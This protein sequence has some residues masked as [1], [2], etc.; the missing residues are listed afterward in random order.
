MSTELITYCFPHFKLTP[1]RKAILDAYL[2]EKYPVNPPV[3]QALL[4]A[5]IRRTA[6]VREH[7]RCKEITNAAA[8]KAAIAELP[9]IPPPIE[10][11]GDVDEDESFENKLVRDYVEVCS[12]P[13]SK[14]LESKSKDSQVWVFRGRVFYAGLCDSSC[15]NHSN[16]IEEMMNYG[17]VTDVE[18]NAMLKR[19]ADEDV[20]GGKATSVLDEND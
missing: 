15:S 10:F 5:D 6:I 18:L 2:D 8:R 4:D 13:G 20:R 1:A 19:F 14:L 12:W 17:Y 3:P 16:G 11:P 7:S 9:P